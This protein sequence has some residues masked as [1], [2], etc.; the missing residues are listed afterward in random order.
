M[1]R[2]SFL[3]QMVL[4]SGFER[5]RGADRSGR[6]SATHGSATARSPAAKA[7]A[8]VERRLRRANPAFG[9][10]L[11]GDAFPYMKDRSAA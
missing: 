9:T 11:V 6:I 2:R 5:A 1:N 10:M 7:E 4:Q 8:M 3:F